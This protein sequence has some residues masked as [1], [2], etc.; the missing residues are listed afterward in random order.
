MT[1]SVFILP[2]A[3]ALLELLTICSR[4]WVSFQHSGL[5][6]MYPIRVSQMTNSHFR[7]LSFSALLLKIEF[8]IQSSLSARNLH[9]LTFLSLLLLLL[10]LQ[11]FLE[12]N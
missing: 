12:E 2:K 11:T 4:H 6:E 5:S 1:V 10:L 8:S 7:L 9:F 3:L